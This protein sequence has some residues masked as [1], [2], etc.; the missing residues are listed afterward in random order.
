M[1]VALTGLAVVGAWTFVDSIAPTG[2]PG[3]RV[4]DQLTPAAAALPGYGTAALPGLTE[5]PRGTSAPYIT[6]TEPH[7]KSCDDNQGWSSVTVQSRFRWSNDLSPLVSHMDPQLAK[8]GWKVLPQSSLIHQTQA[9]WTKTLRS[10][11]TALLFVLHQGRPSSQTWK[12]QASAD[13]VD[14]PSSGC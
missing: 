8:L 14:Q 10:G 7:P 4:L 9:V 13:P 5:V 1:L 3:A 11:S 2:D 6:T 12:F